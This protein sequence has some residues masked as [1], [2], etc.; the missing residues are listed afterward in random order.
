V[1]HGLS[2]RVQPGEF[3]ALIGPSGSGKSTL[4]NIIGL[5]ER[6]T[7]GSYRL[8]GDEVPGLDDAAL[9]LRGAARW[10]SCSSSTTC[11]RPSPRWRT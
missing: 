2:L 6:M 4:L 11:C 7:S 9:T 3:A 1:L 8:Q 10:A 5:L